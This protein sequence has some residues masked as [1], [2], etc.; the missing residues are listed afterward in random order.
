[1]KKILSIYASLPVPTVQAVVDLFKTAGI[2]SA[3]VIGL[4]G[5]VS[6]DKSTSSSIGAVSSTPM[7]SSTPSSQ[8][9]S[10]ASAPAAFV[11]DAAQ[12]K[13]RYESGLCSGCHGLKNAFGSNAV[14]TSGNFKF[15]MTAL[16]KQAARDNLQKYL[17]EEMPTPINTAC[18]D[19][20]AA[21][22]AAYLDTWKADAGNGGGTSAPSN[23]Y[24]GKTGSEI[25]QVAC[26]SCHGDRGQ[27]VDRDANPL[28]SEILIENYSLQTLTKKIA[29]DMPYGGIGTCTGTCANDVAEYILSWK[30]LVNCSVEGETPLPRRLRILTPDEYT[31]TVID[32]L[33]LDSKTETTRNLLKFAP[34]RGY[35]NNAAGSVAA[36]AHIDRYWG[37]AEALS[38]EANLNS[39]MS[40][41][42]KDHNGCATSFTQA[43][44]ERAF[45][46]PLSNDE[47]TE[48]TQLFN[49]VTSSK[50]DAARLVIRSMLMSPSFI[51]R[52][53]MGQRDGEHYTLT[54][55]E[56]ASLLSYTFWGTMPD[57]TLFEAARNNNLQS[58]AQID[59]QM[60]RLL[61]D[62]RASKRLVHFAAQWL[63]VEDIASLNKDA[64]EYPEFNDELA[65]AMQAEFD[66]L[67]AD[68]LLGQNT[69]FA[70]LYTSDYTFVNN[71]LANFY[72]INGVASNNFM[73]V[74][75]GAQRGGILNV[76]AFLASHAKMDQ[77][78]PIARGVGVRTRLLC[79]DF[80][81]PP[82]NVGDVEPL[83]PTKSTR[84]RF[85]AH[86]DN[87]GCRECHEK[88]DPIGFSF[89]RYD[90]IG[91]YREFEGQNVA[92]D[93]S[94][95]LSGLVLMSDSD[96]Q[97]YTGTKGLGA[98]LAE[99]PS[100]ANCLVDQFSSFMHG[101]KKPDVCA[102]QNAAQRWANQ[103]YSLKSLWKE[104]VKAESLSKRQ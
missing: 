97:D 68:L 102:V 52:S 83:D 73:K 75:A 99:A 92:V 95:S 44:G 28:G 37:V 16:T 41:D 43:F 14:G 2:V 62:Q 25:Y 23:P 31:H 89:E 51:Y 46:R 61:G 22:V 38:D 48:Y 35:D 56:L 32:L 40:C 74:T 45:R 24:A 50:E 55:W 21:D 98:I 27:G 93:D 90:G 79:Q 20:C 7:S 29:D 66:L 3:L 15:D 39:I 96:N 87:D 84:E 18:E 71:T 69:K 91:A 53:E 57:N 94:G 54:P 30:V 4:T 72:G 104:I 103:G 101:V 6:D 49:S 1:M 8:A 47:K 12:G 64:G 82:A 34:V 42:G 13:I 19:Q 65:E 33:A 60:T 81:T 80:P 63:D 9:A 86:T 26:E 5:C 76:S 88:I 59:S 85:A 11:G 67:L 78:S 58:D 10:S 17:H 77:S 36:N 100:A 70:D